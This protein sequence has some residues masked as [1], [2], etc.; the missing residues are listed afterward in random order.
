M[1]RIFFFAMEESV[2]LRA[3]ATVIS[4]RDRLRRKRPGQTRVFAPHSLS[5]SV[6]HPYL[7]V[8]HDPSP[9][10][11]YHWLGMRVRVSRRL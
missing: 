1:R 4:G 5:R 7:K 9:P 3:S 10:M 6:A 8:T 11:C 2:P